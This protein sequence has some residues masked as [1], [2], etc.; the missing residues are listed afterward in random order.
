MNPFKALKLPKINYTNIFVSDIWKEKEKVNFNH[1]ILTTKNENF[2]NAWESSRYIKMKDES[3]EKFKWYEKYEIK[4]KSS[5]K[6][7]LFRSDMMTR[8][9]LAWRSPFVDRRLYTD[10]DISHNLHPN[11]SEFALPSNKIVRLLWACQ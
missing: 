3:F 8:V 11:I 5:R 1:C 6:S 9:W 2:F 4:Q 7:S 10:F